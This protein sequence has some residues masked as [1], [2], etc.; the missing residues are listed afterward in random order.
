MVIFLQ[1]NIFTESV[2]DMF[3]KFHPTLHNLPTILI[4]I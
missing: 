2:V 1:F 4:L 3:L